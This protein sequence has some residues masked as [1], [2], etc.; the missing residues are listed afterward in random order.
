MVTREAWLLWQYIIARE[1]KQ[2]IQRQDEEKNWSLALSGAL[3][4]PRQAAIGA[5]KGVND[6]E[7]LY[8]D[9]HTEDLYTAMYKSELLP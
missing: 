1:E 5:V 9:E 4:G 2:Q 7:Q 8:D 6:G 3:S